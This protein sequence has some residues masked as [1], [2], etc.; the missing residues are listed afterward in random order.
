MLEDVGVSRSLM[1]RVQST[2]EM[3]VTL[4]ILYLNKSLIFRTMS[5]ILICL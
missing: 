4:Y 5:N 2:G 1:K 3:T